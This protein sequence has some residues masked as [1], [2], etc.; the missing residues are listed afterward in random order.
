MT[1][2]VPDSA[3]RMHV[4]CLTDWQEHEEH[5][6]FHPVNLRSGVRRAQTLEEFTGHSFYAV[7]TVAPY[8]AL[9]SNAA[10]GDPT[11]SLTEVV[12]RPILPINRSS[13]HHVV[14]KVGH[15]RSILLVL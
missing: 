3:E 7:G 4:E 11:N 13:R 2:A 15:G 6:V 12:P 5:D 8:L 14:P 1:I 9:T 10:I